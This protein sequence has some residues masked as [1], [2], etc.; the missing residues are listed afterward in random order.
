MSAIAGIFNVDER[1]ADR[2][3]LRAMVDSV[4]DRGPDGAA[5]WTEG[6]AG[7]A[8]RKFATTPEAVRE[9]Q[10]WV[11]ADATIRV[12]F[13]GR[14]DNRRELARDLESSGV[15]L[16]EPTDVELV[17]RCFE[18]WDEGAWNRL[19]GD[20]SIAV[21]DSRRRRMLCARDPLGFKPLHYFFDGRRFLCASDLIQILQDHA[22]GRK[23]NEAFLAECLAGGPFT[24]RETVIRNIFRLEGGACLTVDSSGM[25]HREYYDPAAAK[26]LRFATY[27]DAASALRET[28]VEAVRCRM[29]SPG[30]VAADLS[31]G[32]DSSSIVCIGHD[33]VRRGI[34]SNRAEPFSLIYSDP[35]ADEREYIAEVERACDFSTHECHAF[36]PD[37][38]W[39]AD[40]AHRHL[41]LPPYPN[42]AMGQTLMQNVAARGLRVALS[43]H[44]GDHT[45][46][47][48]TGDL[49]ALVRG[50][51]P[52]RLAHALRSLRRSIG[53]GEVQRGFID[54]VFRSAVWPFVPAF[55]RERVRRMLN[56]GESPSFAWLSWLEPA[57][58]RRFDLEDRARRALREWDEKPQAV[59]AMWYLMRDGWLTYAVEGGERDARRLGIDYRHPFCDRRVIEFVSGL[60]EEHRWNQGVSKLLM[61][62]AMKELLPER[63]R[64]RTTKGDFNDLMMR[65]V[66]QTGDSLIDRLEIAEMGWVSQARLKQAHESAW[67]F[68]QSRDWRCTDYMWT[69]FA[70]FGVEMLIRHF[71]GGFARIATT[72]TNRDSRMSLVSP[73]RPPTLC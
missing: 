4:C 23:L 7:L 33:L 16:D 36:E 62:H 17:G 29:R 18:L 11:N 44:G 65:A 14:I 39:F 46:D 43:G 32:L 26:A 51:H 45:M 28:L 5:F 67:R 66:K 72:E 54:V 60:A 15:I 57:F 34:V 21:W 41:E 2:A 30:D 38:A 35:D 49:A 50:V 8:F 12:I 3:M 71:S 47:G 64:K 61:R 22:I 59:W 25:R 69:G 42:Y 68:Y 10:P 70:L 63:I 40:Y 52:V 73:D 58:A 27:D 19:L 37:A 24:R 56:R 48:G 1:P 13:D 31:G 55:A 9:D 6:A 53:S 20:Y